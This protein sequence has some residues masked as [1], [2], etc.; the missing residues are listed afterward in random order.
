VGTAA[1]VNC[2]VIVALQW[3]VVKATGKHPGALLLVVVAG[4][5]TLTWL[6]LESALFT[7]AQTA[8]LVFVFAFGLFAVG[9]TMYAPVLSPLAAAIAP[10]GMVGTTLGALAALRTGISAAG[11]LVAGL[12]I[13]Q[14]LPHLFVL[15]H[16]AI[17][18]AA[19]AVA[20][21]LSQVQRA[22]SQRVD[23][24]RTD[25]RSTRVRP[26]SLDEQAAAR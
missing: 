2:L 11:P 14:H 5:W 12:L 1:A 4:V 17:N 9:E 19:L 21:R 23:N 24:G 3:L 18:A 16:V 15:L 22:A 10:E 25:P 8:S 13:S 26:L 6:T 20:W 7:S